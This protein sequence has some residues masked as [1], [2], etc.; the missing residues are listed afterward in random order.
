MMLLT[1]RDILVTS[2]RF[3][4]NL[5]HEDLPLHKDV[6]ENYTSRNSPTKNLCS[7]GSWAT[8]HMYIVQLLILL[9]PE[10]NMMSFIFLLSARL[11]LLLDRASRV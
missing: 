4:S 3:V 11:S 5:V 8:L 9:V 7:K 2:V 1:T 6:L 10:M